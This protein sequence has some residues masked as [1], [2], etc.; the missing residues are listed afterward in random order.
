MR[1]L[2]R[3][4][5]GTLSGP[6]EEPRGRNSGHLRRYTN[7]PLGHLSGIRAVVVLAEECA[8]AEPA[9]HNMLNI[10]FEAMGLIRGS[11]PGRQQ[12]PFHLL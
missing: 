4:R 5:S 7:Q 9:M 11:E 2:S 3:G 6:L 12:H 8:F 10:G 1:P